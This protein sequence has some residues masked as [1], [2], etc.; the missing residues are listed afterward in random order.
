MGGKQAP[1]LAVGKLEELMAG[2]WELHYAAFVGDD[3]AMLS[4]EDI[5]RINDELELGRA[6]IEL[7]LKSKLDFWNRL[8]WVLVGMAHVDEAKGRDAAR[9]AVEMFQETPRKE[10][11]HRATWKWL[12]PGCG[13]RL[14]VEAFIGGVARMELEAFARRAIA[15]FRFIPVVESNI[16]GK[17]AR[18]KN[19]S[20]W[21]LGPVRVS[22]AN[23]L[24]MLER[25]FAANPESLRS[26]CEY[27]EQSRVINKIPGLVG[28]ERHPALSLNRP[29][30]R[31][32]WT[33][34]I[35]RMTSIIYRVSIDDLFA[36]YSSEHDH[37]KKMHEKHQRLEN[38]V[39]L[40]AGLSDK[41][42]QVAI[43]ESDVM[44]AQVM[45]HL[46]DVGDAST[47]YS[48]PLRSLK[49]RLLD[50]HIGG[51]AA[52]EPRGVKRNLAAIADDGTPALCDIGGLQHPPVPSIFVSDHQGH[53]GI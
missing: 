42:P 27:F 44:G 20:A 3:D 48:F 29:D 28:F 18:V 31:Q 15:E 46:R 4:S 38:R 35:P 2:L 5:Q 40:E 6:H 1:E 39:A 11:H 32:H 41:L 16:E 52:L 25:R 26:F 37:N 8:P 10:L 17:H 49:S 22:L 45:D 34:N 30:H 47:I 19:E 23:R 50:A 43:N 9:R 51:P 36:S 14:Q 13:L 33:T 53:T 12:A 21:N 7:L 24:F